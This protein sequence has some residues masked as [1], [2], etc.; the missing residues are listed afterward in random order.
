MR[1]LS[2]S[3]QLAQ[4]MYTIPYN[5]KPYHPNPFHPIPS[6]F[7]Q[8]YD[9]NPEDDKLMIDLY[10]SGGGMGD[11]GAWVGTLCDDPDVGCRDSGTFPSPFCFP[12][13]CFHPIYYL[14]PSCSSSLPFVTAGP[15]PH[16]IPGTPPPSPLWYNTCP[17]FINRGKNSALSPVLVDSRR[18]L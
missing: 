12:V 7:A 8:F 9:F 13:F 18:I 16:T 1:P 3:V 11:C 4:T 5:T 2:H 17:R 15:G 14:R 10:M 6:H